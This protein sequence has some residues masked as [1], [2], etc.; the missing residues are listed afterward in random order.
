MSQARQRVGERLLEDT[1]LV[2][3][4]ALNKS[5]VNPQLPES[6]KHSI[7]PA[8]K[9]PLANGAYLTI[10]EIADNRVGYK[11][12][13]SFI[14]IRC[15]NNIDK[16]YVEIDDVLARVKALLHGNRFTYDNGT[17]CVDVFYETTGDELEDEAYGQVFREA[18]YRIQYL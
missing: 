2:S 14:V 16:T 7:I 11:L 6:R 3:M 18:Q 9:G 13:E 15:Y 17:N 5:W 8:S 1:E 4:L 12:T 10:R